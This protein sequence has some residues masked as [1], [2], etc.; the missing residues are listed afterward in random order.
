[1]MKTFPDSIPI[2]SFNPVSF[3]NDF[4]QLTK[5]RLAISVVF[6]SVA[7]YLLAVDQI[8]FLTLMGLLFGGFATVGASNA[9]NQ[10]IERKKDSLM[11][12]TKKHFIKP[13]DLV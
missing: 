8:D 13:Y 5:F 6:S 9:F 10:W 7:G 2:V 3:V 12:R 1:M 4:L 11:D